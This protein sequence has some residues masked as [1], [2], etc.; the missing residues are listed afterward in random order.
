M[1]EN[2]CGQYKGCGAQV[3]FE[4]D[5]AILTVNEP[6]QFN[7]FVQPA[8]LPPSSYEYKQGSDVFVS[9]FGVSNI[10]SFA[11][12]YPDRLMGVKLPLI[13]TRRCTFGV[14]DNMVCAGYE[15]GGKDS[16]Q[17]DS[18]GPLVQFDEKVDRATLIGVVSWGYGCAEKGK[19][20]VYAKV[21][22]FADWIDD[23]LKQ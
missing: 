21:A 17:G 11:N 9:G 4:N 12:K 5:L 8:C 23:K 15:A 19:P 2:Y 3:A 13:E 1:H 14:P 20:G 7:S 6:F 10:N 18:G 22:H 16:C